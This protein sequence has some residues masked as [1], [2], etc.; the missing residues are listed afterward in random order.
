MELSRFALAA[1]A[2][3]RLCGFA[4]VLVVAATC[5]DGTVTGPGLPLSGAMLALSPVLQQTVPGGPVIELSKIRAVLTISTTPPES[6]VVIADFQGDSAVIKFEVDVSGPSQLFDVTLAATDVNGD[7]VFRAA[8]TVR[9]YPVGSPSAPAPGQGPKIQLVYSAADASVSDIDL[10]P[11][12]TTIASG[13]TLDLRVTGRTAS[14]GALSSVR[15]GWQARDTTAVAIDTVTGRITAKLRQRSTWIVA[16]AFNG[17]K[18]STRV[19][20]FA[21]VASLSLASDRVLVNRGD[22]LQVAATLADVGGTPLTGRPV[23][24]SSTDPA[25]VAVDANGFIKGLVTGDSALVIATSNQKSDTVKV[26]VAPR[27]V[28]SVATSTD[29][30][31]VFIGQTMAVSASVLDAQG[32]ANPDF[33]VAWSAQDPAIATVAPDG[34]VTGVG[35]GATTVTA[36]AGG[37][38]KAVVVVVSPIPVSHVVVAPQ[39]LLLAAGDAAALSV[40]AFDPQ[41]L[42]LSGRTIAWTSRDPQVATVSAA[43]QVTGVAGGSTYVVAQAMSGTLAV[44]RPDSALVTVSVVASLSLTSHL[45]TLSSYNQSR[46]LTAV[47]R[48]AQQQ[49]VSVRTIWVSRDTNVVTVDSLGGVVRS[50]LVDGT[51]WVVATAGGKSDSTQVVVRQMP[52]IVTVSPATVTRFQ[53]TTQQFTAAVTD[54]MGNAMSGLGIT[55]STWSTQPNSGRV[56]LVSIDPATGLATMSATDFGVDTVYA[57]V[58]TA[59]GTSVVGRAVVTVQSLVASIDVAPVT[60]T[61]TALGDTVVYRATL[62]DSTGAAIPLSGRQLTWSLG[63]TSVARLVK[64]GVDSVVAVAAK[65]GTTSII[66][67]VPGRTGQASLTVQQVATGIGV[68]EGAGQPLVIDTLFL[69]SNDTVQLV[70]YEKDRRGNALPS[71]T[72]ATMSSSNTAVL[73][74]LAGNVAVAKDSGNAVLSVTGGAFSAQIPVRVDSGARILFL[75]DLGPTQSPGTDSLIKTLRGDGHKVTVV[76]P[77]YSFDPTRTQ[78]AGFDVVIHLD[79]ATYSQANTLAAQ[80][81]LTAFVK[82]G[83]GYIAAQWLGYE[84]DSLGGGNRHNRMDDLLL[85]RWGGYNSSGGST[86]NVNCGSCSVTLTATQAG[87]GH[88][89]LAG[90]PSTFTRTY[91]GFSAGPFFTYTVDL[92]VEL[93][94][95]TGGNGAQIP[96]PGIAVRQLTPNGA[97]GTGRV[98]NFGWTA[99]YTLSSTPTLSLPE[100]QQLYLNA[101]RWV[102]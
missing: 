8:D 11:V 88:P 99:N 22:S 96:G 63:D 55:W 40:T 37:V 97:G 31:K 16:T 32:Q 74:I 36:T 29:T 95:A 30:V 28:G 66:A 92:P 27:P 18:D 87:A 67:T 78:L 59:R 60:A 76:E 23:A 5:R 58:Q 14:G 12:D 85:F 21:P 93:M 43:G 47:A 70:A 100:V 34:T 80:D 79:G 82:R 42:V 7:T 77:E 9:A 64:P 39:T 3:R 44:G 48:D 69:S 94:T 53:T 2:L 1:R 4:A 49:A 15:V 35:V 25:K 102:R 26:V 90:I 20:V 46:Q 6:L 10:A 68:A 51:T 81:S 57:T 54:S 41:G 75:A 33:T 86:G 91:D 89:V 62:R 71:P 45:D 98:V 72:A 65:N 52:G 56:A 83:G 24:W 13:A 73:A 50:K 17:V 61:A 38:S 84:R 101:V 19:F